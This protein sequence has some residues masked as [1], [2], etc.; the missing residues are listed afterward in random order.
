MEGSG[1][2]VVSWDPSTIQSGCLLRDRRDALFFYRGARDAAPVIFG[3]PGDA[4]L[5]GAL[6]ATP[7]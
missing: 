7:A 5:L 1:D 2:R 4:T 6:G 3:D